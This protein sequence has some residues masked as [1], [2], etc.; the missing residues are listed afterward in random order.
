MLEN[1]KLASKEVATIYGKIKFDEKGVSKN[2]SVTQQKSLGKLPNFKYIE[3]PKES[4][5]KSTT[6]KTRANTKTNSSKASSVKK[7]AEETK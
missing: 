1:V 3:E 5:P 7:E 2:L 4:K 6:T